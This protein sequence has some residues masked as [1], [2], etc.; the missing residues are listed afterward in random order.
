MQFKR[1]V[2]VEHQHDPEHLGEL[3]SRI[4]LADNIEQHLAHAE[5]PFA[6][7]MARAREDFI[8]ATL[9]LLDVELLSA[10]GIEKARILQATANRYRDL[11]QWIALALDDGKVAAHELDDEEEEPAV[12]IL[13]DMQYGYRGK[14]APDA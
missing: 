14:P 4:A 3:V 9:S 8:V 7:M 12:E 11:C 2:L 13:K 6:G 5:T 1:Y 10:D